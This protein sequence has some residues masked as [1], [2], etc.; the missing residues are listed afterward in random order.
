MV[1]GSIGAPPARADE[2]PQWGALYTDSYYFGSIYANGGDAQLKS[3]SCYAGCYDYQRWYSIVKPTRSPSGHK[4]IQLKSYLNS[5]CIDDNA[6]AAG[7][8]AWLRGCNSGDYQVWEVFPI[9]ST[10][11]VFKSWGAWTL[12]SRHLCLKASGNPGVVKMTTCDTGNDA[13]RWS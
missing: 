3:Q 11:F 12:Q 6:A 8:A 10:K 13:Q 1:F 7:G 9:G 2:P 4:L 5:R